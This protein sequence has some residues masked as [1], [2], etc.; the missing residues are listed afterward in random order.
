MCYVFFFKQK[1]A[2]DMRI[3]DWS[4]DVCS[5]TALLMGNSP[6][7]IERCRRVYDNHKAL[8]INS[9]EYGINYTVEA[10]P[11]TYPVSALAMSRRSA[12]NK[13]HQPDQAEFVGLPDEKDR[14][15]TRLNS[16]NSC[17][18]RMTSYA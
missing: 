3:S 5:S 14:K 6:E 8:T 15:S 11:P 18:T 10:V 16:S 2:Y 13:P 9:I 17:A 4:S 12:V 7:V 1:T